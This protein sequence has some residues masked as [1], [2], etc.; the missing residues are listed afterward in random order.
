MVV[1]DVEISDLVRECKRKMVVWDKGG[2][3]R[4]DSK[5]YRRMWA[6]GWAESSIAKIDSTTLES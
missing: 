3:T 5:G 6:P 1:G 4:A 2:R